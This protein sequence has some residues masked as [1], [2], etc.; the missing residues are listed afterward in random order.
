[1]VRLDVDKAVTVLA[2][3]LRHAAVFRAEY[4]DRI[5]GMDERCQKFRVLLDFHTHRH[6]ATM[7]L[8]ERS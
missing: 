3:D 2:E 1:M 8:T 5:L 6:S 4:V 7:E